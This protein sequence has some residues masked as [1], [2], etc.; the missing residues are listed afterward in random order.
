MCSFVG[1]WIYFVLSLSPG[2]MVLISLKLLTG[3]PLS[4]KRSKAE[5][6][7]SSFHESRLSMAGHP[8][9][10]V[11]AGLPRLSEEPVI[12]C[13]PLEANT[14]SKTGGRPAKSEMADW[15]GSKRRPGGR[16]PQRHD[17]AHKPALPFLDAWY[18]HLIANVFW[19][20]ISLSGE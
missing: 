2:Q 8:S 17:C 7:K 9:P 11:S 1:H 13:A 19:V 5:A 18:K 10:I 12:A 14:S 20:F 6:I 15:R 3:S 4:R 16:K